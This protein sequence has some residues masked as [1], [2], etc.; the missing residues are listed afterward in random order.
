MVDHVMFR[1]HLLTVLVLYVW[2]RARTGDRVR[3]LVEPRAPSIIDEGRD[4]SIQM[5]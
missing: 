2:V 5:H 4:G 3:Q 1:P